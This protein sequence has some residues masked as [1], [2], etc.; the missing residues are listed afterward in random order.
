MATMPAC[1]LSPAKVIEPLHNSNKKVIKIITGRMIDDSFPY[2][3]EFKRA[4]LEAC[5]A[6]YEV[7]DRTRKP[8]GVQE[9]DEKAFYWVIECEE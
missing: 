4:A 1:S 8:D 9:L 6:G 2:A 3:S 5:P 7:R